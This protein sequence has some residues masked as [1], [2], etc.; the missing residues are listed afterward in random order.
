MAIAS[1]A[2]RPVQLE[3]AMNGYWLT[4]LK[5]RKPTPAMAA[6]RSWIETAATDDAAAEAG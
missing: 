5:S 1:R 6:F 2:A 4:S 3:I